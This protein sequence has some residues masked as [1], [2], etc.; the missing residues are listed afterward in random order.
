MSLL[1]YC[2]ADWV[3][4]PIDKRSTTGLCIHYRNIV[5]KL[6]IEAKQLPQELE[7]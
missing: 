6:N 1:G 2:N 4:C 5:S 7:F 3:G